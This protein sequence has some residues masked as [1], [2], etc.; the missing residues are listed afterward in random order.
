MESK[1]DISIIVPAKNT[2][3]YIGECLQS[4]VN[5]DS[6]GFV[7]EVLLVDDASTDGTR[8]IASRFCECYENFF[9]VDGPGVGLAQARIEGL[10]HA[11]G[12]YIGWVD[13]DDY[14]QPAM[15]KVLIDK[16][17]KT[18]AQIVLCDYVFFP[19][20]TPRKKKWFRR[21]DGQATPHTVERNTQLWNKLFKKDYLRAANFSGM[22]ERCSDGSC[23]LLLAMAERITT[24]DDQLYFYRVGHVSM[25]SSYASVE[26]YRDNVLL[27]KAQRVISKEFGLDS[28]W[29]SYFDYRVIYSLLQLALISARNNNLSEYRL[30]CDELRSMDYLNNIYLKPILIENHGLAKALLFGRVV[31]SSWAAAKLIGSKF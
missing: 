23:S 20:E 30:A 26:K 21:I 18:N 17:R 29:S 24:V 15:Y 13:S 4:L 31:P 3:R 8:S 12:E 2:E 1:V 22:L 5:L 14:V 27:T 10:K 11:R 9:L 16:A 28:E 25:S 7:Y 6:R 19:A